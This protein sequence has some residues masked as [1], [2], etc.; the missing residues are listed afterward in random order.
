MA[1]FS[2]ERLSFHLFKDRNHYYAGCRSYCHSSNCTDARLTAFINGGGPVIGG[3]VLPFIFIVIACGAISGFH[4]VIATGTTPK[5]LNRER[6]ILFVGYGAMLV[7]G[8]VALM[9][10]IAA[11][12]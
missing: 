1:A 2:S 3:P 4:A 6:E 7:E 5:M 9:A 11:C 10:L 8:F 12:T